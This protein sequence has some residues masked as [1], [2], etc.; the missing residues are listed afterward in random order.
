MSFALVLFDFRQRAEKLLARLIGHHDL[1]ESG[2]QNTRAPVEDPNFVRLPSHMVELRVDRCSF[3]A[4]VAVNLFPF[5]HESV[6]LE[7]CPTSV[8]IK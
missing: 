2:L 8:R 7:V 6:C 5:G 4:S 1:L 3:M